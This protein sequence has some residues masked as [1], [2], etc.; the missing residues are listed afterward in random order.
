MARTVSRY[1]IIATFIVLSLSACASRSEYRALGTAGV[2]FND[3][4]ADFS[5]DAAR[6][7]VDATSWL[8]IAELQF[9]QEETV[10]QIR[11]A[12]EQCPVA[13]ITEGNDQADDCEGVAIGLRTES[14]VLTVFSDVAATARGIGRYFAAISAIADSTAGADLGSSVTA[15]GNSLES[16]INAIASQPL[17]TS[18]SEAVGSAVGV[19]GDVVVASYLRGEIDRN[20]EFLVDVFE[21][22]TAQITQMAAI[23]SRYAET[24]SVNRRIAILNLAVANPGFANSPQETALWVAERRNA[25]LSPISLSTLANLQ[26][27]QQQLSR[28]FEA[29][30]SDD[31]T[32]ERLAAFQAVFEQMA[33]AIR[34]LSEAFQTSSGG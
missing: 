27:T 4:V 31:L 1:G 5:D 18:Y 3:A 19:I 8:V 20:Y 7:R 34:G 32:P 30:A 17:G 15:A 2:A 23:V 6:V 21:F 26:S 9:R 28:A 12:I 14:D 22:Q 13:G 16:L 10:A 24:A 29:L 33:N 25:V 11:Q